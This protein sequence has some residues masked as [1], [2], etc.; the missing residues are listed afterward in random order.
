MN[1]RL[2]K[3]GLVGLLEVVEGCLDL[4]S[5]REWHIAVLSEEVKTLRNACGRARDILREPTGRRLDTGQHKGVLI[6][7]PNALMRRQLEDLFRLNGIEVFATAKNGAEAV[8][9]YNLHRPAAVTMDMEMPVMNGFE[10]TLRI[11]RID[12]YANVV[13]ISH[14]LRRNQV[15]RAMHC[16]AT[17]Y[18]AKPVDTERLLKV[19]RNLLEAI[20]DEEAPVQ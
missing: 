5:V 2:G 14:V 4:D 3:V 17:E 11:K 7:D 9:L 10:A 13:F 16:G 19:V 15:M 12:P 20:P 1:E 6:V 18:I 8:D